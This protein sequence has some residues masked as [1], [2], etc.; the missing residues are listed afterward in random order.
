[1]SSDSVGRFFCFGNYGNWNAD[2]HSPLCLNMLCTICIGLYIQYVCCMYTA[3]ITLFINTLRLRQNCRYCADD[4][5]KRISWMEF[6]L[7]FR[8]NLFLRFEITTFQHWFRW[9]LGT[10]QAGNHYLKQWCFFFTDAYMRHLTL[11]S[12]TLCTV[13]KQTFWWIMLSLDSASRNC[14]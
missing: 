6:R 5:F 7:C 13:H 4:I 8:W 1:M 14:S 9:W 2:F 12:Y 10:D 3:N 11:T